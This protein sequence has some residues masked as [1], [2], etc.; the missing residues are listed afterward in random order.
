MDARVYREYVGGGLAGK[1]AAEADR[2]ERER[3]AVEAFR[4]RQE[5]EKLEALAAPVVELCK[6]VEIL[7][8]AHLVANGYRRY[9]GKWR[10]VRE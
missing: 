10:R 8:R 6:V 9:Q 1:M 7:T 3:R 2:I 4:E 5:R